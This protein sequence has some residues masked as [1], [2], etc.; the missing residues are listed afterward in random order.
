[1][2]SSKSPP[3]PSAAA[4]YTSTEGISNAR[5][6]LSVDTNLLERLLRRETRC[7]SSTLET[8]CAMLEQ[9][10]NEHGEEELEFKR[11]RRY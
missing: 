3:Q 6:T 2:R 4:T 7:Q 11:S 1:M 9:I 8:R 5:L 10:G